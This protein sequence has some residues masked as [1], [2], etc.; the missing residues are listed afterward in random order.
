MI[1]SDQDLAERLVRS[2]PAASYELEMLCRVAGIEWSRT[3]PTAAVTC[4]ERTRLLVNPDF[5]AQHCPL[6]EHLFLLVMHELW[7]VL[8][9]HTRL[10]ARPTPAHNVAFDAIINAGLAR[11]HPAP[12]YLEFFE[13][14]NPPDAFPGLL[15]RPPIGWPNEP[16]YPSIG[17]K[18]T[19]RVLHALYPP[20]GGEVFEP[21]YGEILQLLEKGGG[22]GEPETGDGERDGTSGSRGERAATPTLLGDHDELDGEARDRAAIDDDLFGDVVR[23]IVA[24]WPPPPFPLGGRDAGSDLRNTWGA[25]LDPPAHDVRH[26]FAAVLRRSLGTRHGAF[27]RRTRIEVPTVSGVGVL[28]N[29]R[30]RLAPARRLLGR[31]DHVVGAAELDPGARAGDAGE[32]AR[33]RRRVRFDES[34]APAPPRT[35]V[36]VRGPTRGRRVPVLHG[37]R[38]AAARAAPQGAAADH[39]RNVDQLRARAHAGVARRTSGAGAHRRLRR[40]GSRRPRG[41]AAGTASPR[42]TPCSRTRARGQRDLEPISDS[43]TVLPPLLNRKAG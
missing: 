40:A 14:L 18:G 13:R 43:L 32:R 28:P 22:G 38:A 2:L 19:E 35:V 9:A 16:Q 8:L 20:P 31:A 10:Y 29:A 42:A 24:K 36:A 6:D 5:V 7:H 37:G 27:R 4:G 1:D 26:A 25:V 30:D 23:R 11:E 15:L 41:R 12:E 17:P 39:G 21:T 33:L 3:I 34:A